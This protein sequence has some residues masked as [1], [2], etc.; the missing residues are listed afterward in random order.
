MTGWG[1][2][3]S[4]AGC[5][6]LSGSRQKMAEVSERGFYVAL[7]VSFAAGV[8]VGW[9]AN[10]Q[11]RRYLDWKKKRLHDKLVETQKKLDLS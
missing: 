11:R 3:I 5:Q 2:R 1:G 10:R 7:L 9:Q 6:T 4:R 8:L